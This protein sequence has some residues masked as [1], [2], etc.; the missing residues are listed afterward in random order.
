MGNNN[1]V[2]SRLE[3]K[4][5]MCYILY[6]FIFVLNTETTIQISL[7]TVHHTHHMKAINSNNSTNINVNLQQDLAFLYQN[8][9]KVLYPKSFRCFFFVNRKVVFLFARN[10]K[11]RKLRIWYRVNLME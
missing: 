2:S 11:D 1:D 10:R 6:K 5:K 4:L 9:F 7:L 3:T 8:T